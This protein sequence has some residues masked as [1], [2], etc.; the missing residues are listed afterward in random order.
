MDLGTDLRGCGAVF[1]FC[2]VVAALIAG[3]IVMPGV[4]ADLKQAAAD[5]DRAEAQAAYAQAAVV[6]AHTVRDRETNLHRETMFQSY[7]AFLAQT[8]ATAGTDDWFITA[9]FVGALSAGLGYLIGLRR[10]H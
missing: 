2:I 1:A 6:E 7:A 4:L 10:T 3:L 5:R 8:A 9:L